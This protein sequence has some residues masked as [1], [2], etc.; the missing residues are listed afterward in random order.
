MSVLRTFGIMQVRM[1]RERGPFC[2]ALGH[3]GQYCYHPRRSLARGLFRESPAQGPD[4]RR[5][6]SRPET[7]RQQQRQIFRAPRRSR[8]GELW[9]VVDLF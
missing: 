6:K 9:R 5:R 2:A 8:N 7:L 1:L 3:S 4:R